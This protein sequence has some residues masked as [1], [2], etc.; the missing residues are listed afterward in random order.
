MGS[1]FALRREQAADG[2][3]PHAVAVLGPTGAGKTTFV[4]SIADAVGVENVVVLD[5]EGRY[6]DFPHLR[7]PKQGAAVLYQFLDA[8]AL[9]GNQRKEREVTVQRTHPNV[10]YGQ[11]PMVFVID[12]LDA[13]V[14]AIET[15]VVATINKDK[16]VEQWQI[17]FDAYTSM[18][19]NL[20]A[21][22]R[23]FAALR[24]RGITF[25]VTMQ[26]G[27]VAERDERGV[28][29]TVYRP[30]I[31]SGIANQVL[32]LT[33]VNL[34]FMLQSAFPYHVLATVS[35]G[36]VYPAKDGYGKLPT[37]LPPTWK[38]YVAALNGQF[39]YGKAEFAPKLPARLTPP[40]E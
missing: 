16:P 8:L 13:L 5:T 11:Q 9:M 21:R 40:E 30:L 33:R 3:E 18:T 20:M 32:A 38:A 22:L 29:R 37:V 19:N 1:P 28:E 26:S 25:V 17:P 39:A 23:A 35:H 12:G 6:D 31:R 34:A 4:R 27:P 24:E 36:G 2:F 7:L 10:F 14:T 15:D